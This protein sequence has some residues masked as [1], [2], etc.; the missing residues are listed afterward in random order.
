MLPSVE[1]ISFLCF[2]YSSNECGVDV[3]IRSFAFS[4][5][6]GFVITTLAKTLGPGFTYYATDINEKACCATKQTALNNN[7]TI[8]VTHTNLVDS[9]ESKYLCLYLF[10]F[11]LSLFLLVYMDVYT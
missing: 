6:S 8:N 5:G 7:V 3:F 4:S 11:F 1:I 10:N 2:L 9:L